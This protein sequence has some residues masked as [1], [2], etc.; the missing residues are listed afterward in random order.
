MHRIY[1]LLGMDPRVR[2]LGRVTDN[3]R[4]DTSVQCF[5]VTVRAGTAY[6]EI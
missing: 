4:C 3:G 2:V 1:N 5:F 6:R